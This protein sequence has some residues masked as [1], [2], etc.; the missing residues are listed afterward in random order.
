[1]GIDPAAMDRRA[2]QERADTFISCQPGDAG[3]AFL[4]AKL[5]AEQALACWHAVHDQATAV[6]AGGD[7]EGR[8]VS[9]L[10]G[11]SSWNGSP[12][13]RSPRTSRCT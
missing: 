6:Y 10:I 11:T 7:P 2:R 4:T 9:M 12:A 1:M 13:S 5:A 3:V 8:S